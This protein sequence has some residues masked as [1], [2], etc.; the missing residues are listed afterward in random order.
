MDV[1][2][3]LFLVYQQEILKIVKLV[4]EKVVVLRTFKNISRLF[5]WTGFNGTRVF[6][7]SAPVPVEE[8]FGGGKCDELVGPY[9]SSHPLDPSKMTFKILISAGRIRINPSGL[10]IGATLQGSR[11]LDFTVELTFFKSKATNT[12]EHTGVAQAATHQGSW[13]M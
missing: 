3:E 8:I 2:D 9:C 12:P 1:P 11:L 6:I 10:N 7:T 13:L 5:F 4:D